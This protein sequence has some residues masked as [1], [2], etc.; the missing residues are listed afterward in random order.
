[1]FPACG[2]RTIA[3]MVMTDVGTLPEFNV[4]MLGRLEDPYATYAEWRAA[5]PLMNGVVG[6]GVTRHAEVSALLRDQRMSSHFPLEMIELAFGQGPRAEFQ[7]HSLL[8]RDGE[9]HRRLRR[10][11]GRAFTPPLVTKLRDHIIELVDGLIERMLDGDPRDVVA[12]LAYPLPTAVICEM[13]NLTGVDRD[14]VRVHTTGL[15]GDDIERSNAEM[16]WFR[17]YLC[18]AL[19]DRTPDAD[20]DLLQRM[21]AA[22]EGDDRLSH[23]EI[24]DNAVLLFFAGFETTK[25]VLA[26]GVA[27]LL[28]FPDQ[29]R[30]LWDTPGLARSAV[31]EF[32][33]F[34]TPAFNA[35]RF[36]LAP[37]KVGG[38][39][40]KAGR[41]VQLLLASANHDERAFD[42]PDQLDIT[43]DPNRHV[44]FAGGAHYCLGAMLA[45]LEAET[46]FTRLAQR[47]RGIEAAGEPAKNIGGF[48]TYAEVP[49]RLFPR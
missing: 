41:F 43:R 38:H 10:L 49:V 26:S 6:W 29:Q 27:A 45:R 14:E 17:D 18:A 13:L 9:D 42:R 39:I 21:L 44:S 19:A 28:Q 35:P 15:V 46:V 31:E 3:P 40:I 2:G 24:I 47:T 34:D 5:G 8:N 12:D 16:A 32:L 36:T 4:L 23:D 33:R 1:M 7:F 25:S 22:E 11:M 37:V 48:G 20:G 30:L